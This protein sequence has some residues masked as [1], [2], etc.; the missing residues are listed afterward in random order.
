[1]NTK[2]IAQL[3]FSTATLLVLSA[4]GGGG[5]SSAPSTPVVQTCANGA[6]NYPTCTAPV[7]PASLQQAL[8]ANY[9]AGSTQS[10][11]FKALN[12]FRS[13]LGLGPVNQNTMIDK[14]ALNHQLYNEVSWVPGENPHYEVQ[15]RAGF[16]GYGVLDRIRAAGFTNIVSGGEV[17]A[18]EIGAKAIAGFADTV[19]HRQILMNEEFTDVGI[20]SGINQGTILDFGYTDGQTNA[21]NYIGVYPTD[22][23]TGIF[24]THALESP[25]PFSDLEMTVENMCKQTS[26]PISIQSQGTT[27]LSVATFTIREF[28]TTNDLP[29]RL[30]QP[31]KNS[32]RPNVAFI[33]G[34]APFKPYTTY[35]VQFTGKVSGGKASTGFDVNKTWSFTTGQNYLRCN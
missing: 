7:I 12:D 29:V 33:V 27:S 30:F 25:N 16:T 5:S 6:P 17:M 19:Y 20:L 23:Q 28:G 8:P 4:C 3:A 11:T 21:S 22:K 10:E 31:G 34:K 9:T 35:T 32:I 15:G 13:S 14:A 18:A 2:Q 26:Y 1:M 24:L